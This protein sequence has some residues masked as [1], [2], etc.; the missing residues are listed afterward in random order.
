MLLYFPPFLYLIILSFKD[1]VSS[2]RKKLFWSLDL[3]VNSIHISKN[4]LII[5]FFSYFSFLQ[6]S[7]LIRTFQNTAENKQLWSTKNENQVW[8]CHKPSLNFMIWWKTKYKLNR[9]F[10]LISTSSFCFVSF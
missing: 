1:Y 9:K 7:Y 10:N 6:I 8:I 4:L 2:L 3:N 5:L